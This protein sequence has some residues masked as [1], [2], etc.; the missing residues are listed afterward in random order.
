MNQSYRQVKPNKV[1]IV[2]HANIVRVHLAPAPFVTVSFDEHQ[3][4]QM[5]NG[6]LEPAETLIECAQR[7]ASLRYTVTIEAEAPESQRTLG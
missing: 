2:Y 4:M 7:L 1:E 3:R 5:S 6:F